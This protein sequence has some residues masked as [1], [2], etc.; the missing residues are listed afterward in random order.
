MTDLDYIRRTFELARLGVALTSPGVMVG[1]VIV[2]DDEIVGEG[3]YT[4]DGVEHAEIRALRQAG[5]AARGSTVYT[6]L[7]PCS[8]VG[9]TPPCAQ[10]LVEAG[11]S[12][13]VAAM[14]DPF[15]AVNG[16]GLAMLRD[17]GI[18]IVC[19]LLQDEARQLNEAF[20]TGL[21]RKR[22]FGILKIAMTLDGKIATR[23]GDSQWITS[24]ASR[25]SVQ[26]LRHSVDAI[27]TGSGTFLKDTPQM[28]DRTGLPRRRELQRIVLDR[29]SR[30]ASTT[31]G[32]TVFRGSLEDLVRHMEE[33]EIQSFLLECGPDLAFNAIRSGIIDK[34]VM[35]V[36]PTLLGGREIP[37]IGGEG[38][39]ELANAIPLHDL[40]VTV[41]DTDMTI[42]GYVY[43][44]H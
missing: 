39:H 37:A 10:A 3:F 19:G 29:R 25:A 32:W 41:G 16:K 9:R 14:Q 43:R 6:S 30:I 4:W 2:K 36:A 33:L 22:A 20:L 11:V 1:A 40:A 5:S 15:P 26:K 42:T 12:R 31:P 27:V 44:D 24:E 17:A 13:V 8:H 34:L 28:T 7:E 21:T 23:S 38:V 18:E 35:F